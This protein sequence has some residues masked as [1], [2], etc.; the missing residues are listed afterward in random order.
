MAE[1]TSIQ[2]FN[3]FMQSTGPSYLTNAEEVINEAA[4]HNYV[5]NGL[6]A[7]KGSERSIQGGREIRDVVMFD[8]GSTYSHYK[9]NET[10]TWSMPQV[11]D[12]ITQ[13]WRFMIDHMS[14]TDAEV[15]LNMSEGAT[16]DNIKGQYKHLKRVKEQRLWTSFLNGM[17]EDLF[18]PTQGNYSEMEGSS[19]N[20]PASLFHFITE[21]TNI[22]GGATSLTVDGD[23]RGTI[24]IG[25][26]S[27]TATVQGINPMADS[28]TISTADGSSTKWSNQISYYDSGANAG[29]DVSTAA[30]VNATVKLKAPKD[31]MLEGSSGSDVKVHGLFGAFDEMFYKV[32]YRAPNKYAEYFE[33]TSFQNQMILCSRAGI[34]AYK[35]ALRVSNDRLVGVSAEDAGYLAP[36]YAGI[37]LTYVSQLDTTKAY[38]KVKTATPVTEVTLTDRNDTTNH[39]ALSDAGAAEEEV[40][41]VDFGPRYYFVNGEYLNM[42]FHARRYM[43]KHEVLRHPNQPFTY[44]QPVDC[45]MNLF[46]RSR[47]RLGVI[48]PL[49][50]A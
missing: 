5:F 43:V 37:P 18:K 2:N 14:W 6:F 23:P 33:D 19:G 45:W 26:E 25:T 38:A 48:K 15:E 47:A 30:A 34:N 41:V 50:T 21:R 24:P 12:T 35:K 8:T 44:V 10:F 46:C 22:E 4:K 3:D 16:R 42:F 13:H 17:E 28:L 9:P 49:V 1:G 40:G 29:P 27:S 7:G 39:G 11:T 32:Q 36:T 20:L 31:D